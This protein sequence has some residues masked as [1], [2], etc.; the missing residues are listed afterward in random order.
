MRRRFRNSLVCVCN[1]K[2][3]EKGSGVIDGKTIEW[4]EADQLIVI[5]L[6]SLTG[7]A[8]KYSILPEKYQAISDK[9]ENVSWG[10]LVQLTFS[11]KFVS[12]VEVLADWL[13]EFY[14]ED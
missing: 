6:E 13:T 2:H 1:E 8:I 11:G 3:R 5:P 10:A 12:D 4:D 9:L 7:K 14:Q